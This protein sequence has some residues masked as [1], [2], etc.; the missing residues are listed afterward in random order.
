V[1]SRLLLIDEISGDTF[2]LLC[3]GEHLDKEYYR[4]TGDVVGLI[5]RYDKLLKI[6]KETLTAS[7]AATPKPL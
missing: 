5:Q 1:G 3:N 7:Y 2:R 4:K 6:T